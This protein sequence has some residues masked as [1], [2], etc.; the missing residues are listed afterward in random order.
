MSV[1]IIYDDDS[2]IK[3]IEKYSAFLLKDLELAFKCDYN[4]HKTSFGEPKILNIIAVPL[5]RLTDRM[6][7]S[8]LN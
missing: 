2:P 3:R 6:D 4:G 5:I 7:Y 8:N 1:L